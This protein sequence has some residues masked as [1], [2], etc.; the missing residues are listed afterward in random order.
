VQKPDTGRWPYSS[1]R[2][3]EARTESASVTS[4]LICALKSW[5]SAARCT[6]GF[7][8]TRRSR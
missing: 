2:L 3:I 8:V 7:V 6:S 4:A 1:R 5:K